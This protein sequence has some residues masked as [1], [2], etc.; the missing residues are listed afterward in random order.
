LLKPEITQE[1]KVVHSSN[2]DR[3]LLSIQSLASNSI[4]SGLKKIASLFGNHRSHTSAVMLGL[5]VLM[6]GSSIPTNYPDAVTAA[7]SA[8]TPTP[9]KLQDGYIDQLHHDVSLMR[10]Q[11]TPQ[12]SVLVAQSISPRTAPASFANRTDNNSTQFGGEA[13]VSIEVSQPKTRA[14]KS[15]ATASPY[16]NPNHTGSDGNLNSPDEQYPGTN[17]QTTLGFTWPAAGKI[18]SKFGRRWGRMHKGIDIAGPIGTPI[19]AAADGTVIVAGW[20]SGGY[21]NLV[22][23][24]HGDGT[25]TRYGHNSQL[26]VSV[27][28]TVRQGQQIARMGSTGY[29]TGSHLHFEIRPSGGRAVNPI[30]LLPSN[31]I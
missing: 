1:A 11:S 27:G 4:P 3:D 18:T 2:V 17:G 30:A 15:V 21:G 19:N 10:A 31:N 16:L 12:H 14:F 29:S 22:E 13:S 25:T 8:P 5:A 7:E 6:A 20:K 28:Q 23:I 26:S 9:S 24:R